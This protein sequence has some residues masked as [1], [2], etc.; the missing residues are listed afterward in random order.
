L[1]GWAASPVSAQK[2]TGVTPASGAGGVSTT[3]TVAFTFNAD[4]EPV[5]DITWFANGGGFPSQLT[6]FTY[7]WTSP[8]R[9]VATKSG[10]FPANTMII[11]SL[12][13]EGFFDEFGFPLE[14]G[15]QNSGFFTTGAGSGGGGSSGTGGA[16][17]SLIKFA[18]HDQ[19]SAADPVLTTNFIYYFGA[20]ASAPQ[21][22]GL[23]NVSLTIPGGA[24]SNLFT[25]P[26]TPTNFF[27]S[28]VTNSLTALNTKFPSGAYSF[29]LKGPSSNQTVAVT[30]PATAF[31]AAPK[32]SNFAAGQAVDP[33]A[34]FTLQFNA[35]GVATEHVYI[36]ITDPDSSD[37]V[38]ESPDIL[39]PGHLLGTAT[40]VVLPAGT[41]QAGKT[42][43]VEIGRWIVSTNLVGGNGVA[44]GIG[45]ITRTVLK[46]TGGAVTTIELKNPTF[47]S[48]FF[49]LEATLTANQSYSLQRSTNT[50]TWESVQSVFAVAPTQIF[51]DFAPPATNAI[52][53]VKKD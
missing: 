51:F 17:V 24:V 2:L 10:G 1:L 29:A 45:S 42:Y 25:T 11:W 4:M 23:T 40:S 31:P 35:G 41:F 37:D 30:M 19:L 15:D 53:R 26:F 22:R 6:G 43:D 12:N 9:L 8:R 38:Y 14:A 27:L 49:S 46:T 34:S 13:E 39:E 44:T 36:N 47:N 32:F 7:Q 20:N 33:A 50:T 5:Q 3:T 48:G 28:Y 52:Y 16:S 21:S 18:N